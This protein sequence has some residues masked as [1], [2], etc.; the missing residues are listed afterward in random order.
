MSARGA[1]ARGS[2]HAFGM[3]QGET[4]EI[5]N[6]VSGDE[7]VKVVARFRANAELR[8][9]ASGLLLGCFPHWVFR[10][11]DPFG[12]YPDRI[13]PILSMLLCPSKTAWSLYDRGFTLFQQ[14]GR[15]HV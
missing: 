8:T 12:S 10:R 3:E 1:S 9:F 6:T 11:I 5:P 7:C 15:A 13:S 14:I 4:G 2:L